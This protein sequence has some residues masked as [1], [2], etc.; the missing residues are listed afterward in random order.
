MI[1]VFP[2]HR[3]K[4]IDPLAL[5]PF[6]CLHQP[7]PPIFCVFF[8]HNW[9]TIAPPPPFITNIAPLTTPPPSGLTSAQT[10]SLF[11]LA[12]RKTLTDFVCMWPLSA[13]TIHTPS[14]SLESKALS[15]VL[16]SSHLPLLTFSDLSISISN[17]GRGGYLTTNMIN[18]LKD[19]VLEMESAI[20]SGGFGLN[21]YV[22]KFATEAIEGLAGLEEE[23][24]KSNDEIDEVDGG[25]E[26]YQSYFSSDSIEDDDDIQTTNQVTF[27]PTKISCKKVLFFYHLQVVFF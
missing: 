19:L 3:R 14:C 11:T 13:S 25:S 24:W 21:R 10:L 18:F 23:K 2:L 8:H 22:A 9:V 17:S 16:P 5:N 20:V 4:S 1:D 7:L 12:M 6:G 15:T 26:D 27:Q